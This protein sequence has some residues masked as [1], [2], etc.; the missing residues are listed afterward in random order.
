[1]SPFGP[2]TCLMRAKEKCE[3]WAF[4]LSLLVLSAAA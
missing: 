4:E 2:E 1:M 3:S